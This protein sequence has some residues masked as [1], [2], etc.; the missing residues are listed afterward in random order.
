M[1]HA[2]RANRGSV[3]SFG[4]PYWDYAPRAEVREL[5][6]SRLDAQLRAASQT[7]AFRHSVSRL[8]QETRGSITQQPF[9]TL[10]L[11]TKTQLR[12]IPPDD[13][14]VNPRGPFHMVRGTGGTS[15]QPVSVFWTRADWIAFTQALYRYSAPLRQASPRRF[16]NGYNQ[17]HVAGPVF[18]DLV[19]A[20]GGT[21]IP[22]HFR[23][24]DAQALADIERVGADA[25]IITPKAGSGKGGS[26]ED[27][28]AIEP[29]FLARLRIKALIVS[30]T[31]LDAELVE[32]VRQQGV[33]AIVNYYGSTEAAPA[34]ASCEADPTAFHVSS[35]HV[36]VEVVDAHGQ[37]VS[38]GT[39]GRVVVSRIGAESESRLSPAGGTQLIRYL[40]GDSV[41][42]DEE[43]CRCGR[44]SPRLGAIE[45]VT[46]LEDKLKGGCERWD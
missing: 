5:L 18:D 12:A 36:F 10:P 23:S 25:L 1:N 30:S 37:Q 14:L 43:P 34:G 3:N 21:S 44:T 46:E 41:V 39:R 40:N 29:S 31:P 33:E 28:L 2:L 26:L 24:T 19:R 22:R 38:S 32:E 35:G 17:G 9:E 42:Y 4:D 20:L 8:L 11:L 7:T 15:G 13:L 16:W 45:R 27:L 6:L